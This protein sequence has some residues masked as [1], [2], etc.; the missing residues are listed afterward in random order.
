MEAAK[1]ALTEALAA[2]DCA[3]NPADCGVIRA[4]GG[5]RWL[6]RA[7]LERETAMRAVGQVDA[8]S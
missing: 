5:R 1:A 6:E 8:R 7:T 2:T 4:C 3:Q